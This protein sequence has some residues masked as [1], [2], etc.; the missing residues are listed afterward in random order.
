MKTPEEKYKSDPEY[1][2][3]VDT[4]ESFVHKTQFTPSEIRECA[5]LACI[6]YEIRTANPTRRSL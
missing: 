5:M 3:L 2:A 6:H 1:H 4:L